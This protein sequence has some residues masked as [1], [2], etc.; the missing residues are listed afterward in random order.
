[1]SSSSRHSSESGWVVSYTQSDVDTI[2]EQIEQ[3]E[4]AKRR[5]LVLA[6]TIV[7]AALVGAVALLTTSYA[8]YSS[9]ESGKKQL[10][11]EN[12]ALKVERDKY[13]QQ[14]SEL[15]AEKQKQEKV[16]AE[17][18]AQIERLRSST[19]LAGASDSDIASFAR[20][21]NELPQGRIELDEKPPDKLFRRYWNLKTD[22]GMETY[23]LIRSDPIGDKWL[24][25]SNLVR[26]MNSN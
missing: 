2:R 6:L 9:S 14:V 5:W 3:N 18:Q 11:D 25:Y 20:R 16:R 13:Q 10:A 24:V 19:S 22:S 4:S 17:A 15:T 12:A 26:R 1:M 8:L 23:A 21:I 7:I